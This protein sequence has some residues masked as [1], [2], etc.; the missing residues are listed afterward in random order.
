MAVCGQ[1]HERRDDGHPQEEQVGAARLPDHPR[2][3]R[4]SD[5]IVHPYLSAVI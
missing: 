1:N 5:G 2:R 4:G 3:T